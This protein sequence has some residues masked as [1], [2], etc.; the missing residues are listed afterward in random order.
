MAPWQLQRNRWAP[1]PACGGG[2]GWGLLRITRPASHRHFAVPHRRAGG[3]AFGG[4]DDGIGVNAVV[5]VQLVD[6]AGL[7]EMLDTESFEPV[8]A[9]AA[10]PTQRCRMAVDHGNDAAVAR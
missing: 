6:G 1:S 7:A 3:E 8:A 2:L 5:T 9:Y 4:V 10:E